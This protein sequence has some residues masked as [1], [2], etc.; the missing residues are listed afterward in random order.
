MA[1]KRNKV[2]MQ[3]ITHMPLES[4]LKWKK[5]VTKEYSVSP[6]ISKSR[7]GKFIGSGSRFILWGRGR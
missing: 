5:P 3:A 1:I 2:W 4:I 7:I 6:L